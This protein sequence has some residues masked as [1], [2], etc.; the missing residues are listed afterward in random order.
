MTNPEEIKGKEK[1]L[2]ADYGQ[3]EQYNE[4][5]DEDYDPTKVP[6]DKRKEGLNIKNSAAYDEE[7]ESGSSVSDEEYEEEIKLAEKKYRSI[8]SDEG[9]LIKTRRG[10]II[11][12]EA[13]TANKYERIDVQ[14]TSE[15]VNELWQRL[16][17]R[18]IG[19]VN[20][21]GSVMAEQ[22]DIVNP[23]DQEEK[24]LIERSYKFAGQ[25]VH[26]KKWVLSSSAEA[27]EYSNSLK[28]KNEG[29][30][31]ANKK[32]TEDKKMEVEGLNFRR[33]LKRPQLLE[34]IISGTVKP[35]L[36]TLEKSKLDWATFVDKEGIHTELQLHNKDGYLAKRDFLER[37]EHSKD[38]KYKELRRIQLQQQLQQQQ[39]TD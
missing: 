3:Q 11:E 21:N 22:V 26:E 31:N 25:L 13:A 35:K 4:S 38:Q 1:F 15:H 10:R 6:N 29:Q 8:T 14:E 24:I 30:E 19:R 28:F 32:V 9:G 33:H 20:N 12:E 16:K 2:N 39:H 17:E 34:Q 37:V 23:D 36:T 7:N 27:R 5:E 18:A